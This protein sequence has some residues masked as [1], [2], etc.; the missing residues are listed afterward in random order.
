MFNETY[1]LK[2]GSMHGTDLFATVKW[3]QCSEFRLREVKSE[4]EVNTS[5]I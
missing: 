3:G 4:V 1:L 5:V 2:N